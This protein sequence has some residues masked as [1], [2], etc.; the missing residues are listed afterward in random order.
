MI[1]IP[2]GLAPIPK[3]PTTRM[4]G[5]LTPLRGSGLRQKLAG[6]NSLSLLVLESGLHALS[7]PPHPTPSLGPVHEDPTNH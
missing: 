6:R 5:E 2:F 4:R 7:R 3:P 1:R